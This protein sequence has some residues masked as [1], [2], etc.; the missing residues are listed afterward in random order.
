VTSI[1]P[2]TEVGHVDEALARSLERTLRVSLVGVPFQCTRRGEH[3]GH[4]A[5]VPGTS[6]TFRWG[7]K[8]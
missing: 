5:P 7:N 3:H 2:C 8:P 1:A 4:E 6:G